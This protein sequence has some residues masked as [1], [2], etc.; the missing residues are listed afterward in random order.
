LTSQVSFQNLCFIIF[1]GKITNL[2]KCIET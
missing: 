2:K 1:Y